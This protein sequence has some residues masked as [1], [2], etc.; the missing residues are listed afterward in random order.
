[1][2]RNSKA[3][4][5]RIE[6]D[7]LS[8]LEEKWITGTHYTDLVQ[9]YLSLWDVKNE[10]IEDIE[11][12]GIKVSGM[13]GPKSNPSINDLNKTNAQMLKILSE[14]G[15]KASAEEKDDDDDF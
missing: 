4:R 7:L 8:Q 1:L 6:K 3:Q 12:Q 13:H 15:L 2:A 14:L 5:K 9:D 11:T 10:L